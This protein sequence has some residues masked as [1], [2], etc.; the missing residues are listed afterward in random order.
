MDYYLGGDLFQIMRSTGYVE[1]SMARV[2]LAEVVFGFEYLHEKGI[3]YRDLKVDTIYQAGKCYAG[4]AG[5]Y[6][7][8]GF[9]P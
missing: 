4:L 8:C 9:R 2:F 6:K 3:L 5:P 7:D 1:E